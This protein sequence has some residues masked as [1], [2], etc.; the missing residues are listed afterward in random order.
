MIPPR[1]IPVLLIKDGSLVK[2]VKFKEFS[3]IGDPCNTVRIFNALEV[4]EL[5]IL[6]IRASKNNETPNIKLLSELADECFMP[7]GYGGG[8]TSLS[9]AKEIFDLGFEKIIINTS[10]IKQPEFIE[11]LSDYFGSQAIVVSIDF[12]SNIFGK[13]IVVCK[14]GFEFTKLDPIDWAKEAEAKGAGEI[15]LTS[16]ERE[17][18]WSGIDNQTVRL[19]A[20]SVSIPVVAHGGIG[21]IGDIEDSISIG[22]ASAVGVGSLV[23]Y[24]KKDMGVLVNFPDIRG[25]ESKKMK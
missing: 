7:L 19:V 4:D 15:F 16:I 6:D 11:K 24:Q 20:Q 2:T 5:F 13:K 9:Q 22:K 1:V 10:A 17:G 23:V 8:I 25:L 18:T 12:K 21:S 3:Y 14:S